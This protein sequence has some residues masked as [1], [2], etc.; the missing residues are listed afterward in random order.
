MYKENMKIRTTHQLK[1]GEMLVLYVSKKNI[2]RMKLQKLLVTLFLMLFALNASATLLEDIVDGKFSSKR[3]DMP[4]SMN[5]GEHFTLLK[6]GTTLLRYNYRTGHIT[7]TLL[8]LPSIKDAPVS[9]ISGY[10]L[11]PKESKI[12]VYHN[13]QRRYRHSFTADYYIFDRKHKEFDPL[14]ASRP[15]EDPVFSADDRYIAF[16]HGNNLFMKKVDFKTD[17]QI[18]KDGEFGKVING[19]ADWVYEEEF[20][21]TRFYDWCPESK[22]LAYVRFNE[23]DVKEFSL[24]RFSNTAEKLQ[25][26]PLTEN[27]KYP[28]AGEK[29]S[30]VG[31]YVYDD[32]NKTTRLMNLLDTNPDSYIPRIKWTNDPDKLIIY[33]L[34]RHQNR[35]DM[36]QTNPKTGISRLLL[37]REDKRYVDYQDI[38]GTI[39]TKDNQFFYA[40]SDQDGYRHIYQYRMDGTVTRQ[41]TKGSWDVTAF[42]GV[43]EQRGIVYYQ[44]SE[45]SPTS[46]DIYAV[47]RRGVKTCLTDQKSM[48]SANFSK[49]FNYFVLTSSSVN[50]PHQ[51]SVRN[52]RGN[53]V[54]ELE[55]N[56][57]LKERYEQLELPSKEFF[58]FKTSEGISLNG[59][60]IKPNEFNATKKHPVVMVQYS[61]PG[62]QQVLNQWSIGWEYFLATKGYIVV[63]VDGRG[64][65]GRGAEFLKCT[66]MQMGVLETKDQVETALYLGALPYIDKNRIAI[67]GWSYGGSMTLWAMST[68]HPVFKA[69][70][71]VAPVTDWRLYDTAYTERFMR[72]PEENAA[73]YNRTSAI[74]QADKLNGRLLLIHGTADDNVHVQNSYVYTQS[75]I[76]AG[77]QFDMHIYTDK[78]HSIGGRSTRRH[79]YTLKYEFLE[80]NL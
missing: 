52:S 58:T 31:V 35:L 12:L 54:R 32:F 64:T 42:Y 44:S 41:V 6:D 26:Y 51:I 14:S 16:A 36:L 61:G 43:D 10:I 49:N 11:S 15:Q 18:T 17:I 25:L 30:I 57:E 53:L 67:W 8:H 46:R 55:N 47:D 50:Q 7:D 73:G 34:N 2:Y 24:Q 77:K 79:L 62:S 28:K 66:Y 9:R 63:S 40:L 37:R 65:G 20:S 19:I 56:S 33:Q 13:V 38:D 70:I 72:T 80:R 71:S 27:F 23:S 1:N 69:G 22:L 4:R 74:Q 29:N 76:D 21:A 75:L 3:P 45:T 60:M 39:F 48:N 68:G 59:W 78:D 5:D